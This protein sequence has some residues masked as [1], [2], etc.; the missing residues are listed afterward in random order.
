MN[1]EAGTRR[2]QSFA[3]D[4]TEA[5]REF[6]AAV[7]QKD[8]ALVLFFCCGAYDLDALA[9]EMRRL[10]EG[11]QVVGCTTAGEIGL[12]GYSEPSLCGA[13]FSASD[14]NAVS[15]CIDGLQ[16]F[17]IANGRATVQDLV[18]KLESQV[19]LVEPNH[20]FGIL[21]IDGVSTREEPVAHCLH[22]ALGGVQWI[23]GSTGNNLKFRSTQLYFEGRFSMDSAALIVVHTRLP[24]KLFKTQHFV[25][26]AIRMVVTEADTARRLV[27]EINGRPA[28][29]ELARMLGLGSQGL[30]PESFSASP[31]A[32][33]IDN[34][35]YVR[36][37]Q[38]CN[39]DGSLTF[40]CA[41]ENGMVLRIANRVD[42]VANLAET[43]AHI[44]AEIGSLQLV[45]GFDCILRRLE[46][47]SEGKLARIN[48]ILVQNQVVGF[49]TYGEQYGSL[50][51]NQSFVGLAIG[52]GDGGGANV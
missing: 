12:A 21:L 44:R 37:I 27:L 15:G 36:S 23:G 49:N 42:I 33:L 16:N 40:Y 9:A 35:T 28:A 8:M 25:A 32:V 26:S 2:A 5:V 4:A 48:E 17:S 11:V 45:L 20:S 13:S 10:F 52:H 38:K 31:L 43:F 34:S 18:Q 7:T 19:G 24:F 29:S 14:F 6:H 39:P 46:I 3:K 51:V 1:G 22:S 41:V 50:H 47:S 30:T